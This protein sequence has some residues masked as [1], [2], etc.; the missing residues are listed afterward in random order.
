[1]CRRGEEAGCF[2]KMNE[3][4]MALAADVVQDEK[5]GFIE[6]DR[7]VDTVACFRI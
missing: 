6:N 4:N 2:I 7:N 1:M 5:T 3:W